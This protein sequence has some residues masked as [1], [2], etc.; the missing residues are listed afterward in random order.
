MSTDF[1]DGTLDAG[2]HSSMTQGNNWQDLNVGKVIREG[3]G[4]LLMANLVLA[5]FQRRL[6]KDLGVRPG[7]GNACRHP[8]VP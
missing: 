3:K 2:R 7:E 6:G 1:R 8:D 5:S 4:F